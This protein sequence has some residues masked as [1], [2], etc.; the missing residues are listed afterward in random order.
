MNFLRTLVWM[1]I[2]MIML[3][4]ALVF[5]GLLLKAALVLALLA[6]AYYWFSHARAKR[7][8][9]EPRWRL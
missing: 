5:V 4:V 3:C 1:S 8:K 7:R 2:L 9:T 6:L